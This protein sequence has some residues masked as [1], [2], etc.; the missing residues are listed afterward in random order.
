MLSFNEF[1]SDYEVNKLEGLLESIQFKDAL[2]KMKGLQK[3]TNTD[4]IKN[5]LLQYNEF[6]KLIPA[7]TDIAEANK[8]YVD[9]IHSIKNQIEINLEAIK[10]YGIDFLSEVNNL[11][12]SLQTSL[13]DT[14]VKIYNIK[15]K[16]HGSKIDL[17]L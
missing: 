13:K 14:F 5:I 3:Y 2:V 12:K 17:F 15:T 8:L 4:D 9:L 10:L 1:C 7:S 6:K 16:S 11:L